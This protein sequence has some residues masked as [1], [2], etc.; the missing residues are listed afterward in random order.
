MKGS[1][2]MEGVET[3]GNANVANEKLPRSKR[4]EPFE[5]G[6]IG[7]KNITHDQ[8]LQN[9]GEP[10]ILAHDNEVKHV[11]DSTFDGVNYKEMY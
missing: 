1:W 2:S 7:R 11:G 3:L 10:Y 8:F 5:N 4:L 6:G 9:S